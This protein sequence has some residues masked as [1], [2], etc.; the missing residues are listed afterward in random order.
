MKPKT[1][2]G[3]ADDDRTAGL[4]E[5]LRREQSSLRDTNT[6]THLLF[7][8][9][10]RDFDGVR[11]VLTKRPYRPGRQCLERP[12]DAR[13]VS[14]AHWEDKYKIFLNGWEVYDVPAGSEVVFKGIRSFAADHIVPTHSHDP[15]WIGAPA[16]AFDYACRYNAGLLALRVAKRMRLLSVSRHNI[17]KLLKL[18]R[19]KYRYTGK[20][21][22]VPGWEGSDDLGS[23]V[24]VIREKF[25]IAC[26]VACQERAWLR[27]TFGRDAD[28]SDQKLRSTSPVRASAPAA[29]HNQKAMIV[30]VSCRV[31][32]DPKF[33]PWGRMP[34][35]VTAYAFLNALASSLVS[36]DIDGWLCTEHTTPWWK[37]GV[38]SSEL[39]VS[40]RSF[41]KCLAR[42][43]THPL[44]HS[45]W[46]PLLF[47][48]ETR[49]PE[50]G[51]VD[52]A[53]AWRWFNRNYRVCKYVLR[54][55]KSKRMIR[56]ED[57]A[58][59]SVL[60]ASIGRG[61]LLLKHEQ[62]PSQL[63]RDI[64]SAASR[65]KCEAVV[66]GSVPR[67]WCESGTPP[68]GFS[69]LPTEDENPRRWVLKLPDYCKVVS[70][71]ASVLIVAVQTTTIQFI[72]LPRGSTF[73]QGPVSMREDEALVLRAAIADERE[74][75]LSQAAALDRDV[76]SAYFGCRTGDVETRGFL[77]RSDERGMVRRK[78]DGFWT[79]VHGDVR[80]A[81]SSFDD[82][83][84]RVHPVVVEG[85]PEDA[86][87]IVISTGDR[88]RQL[89]G[90]AAKKSKKR[91]KKA[92]C[93]R[94]SRNRIPA[95][96]SVRGRRVPTRAGP[97]QH[98]DGGRVVVMDDP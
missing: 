1:P 70:A 11:R 50:Y 21:D 27:A 30:K 9:K 32:E 58:A 74:L 77:R 29:T 45:N 56:T 44:D 15:L 89:T 63:L 65:C 54:Q 22:D 93:S 20:F 28:M 18:A 38:V 71:S 43:Q 80:H 73:S 90:G 12:E 37:T 19:R 69:A 2:W 33:R 60:H 91:A 16:I 98:H 46:Y 79:C 23:L 40:A 85:L 76:W 72:D 17:L 5:S 39:I 52:I 8:L 97:G 81:C 6:E 49:P 82:A 34:M 64:E 35:D 41:T 53:F 94:V 55:K 96:R 10:Y 7:G 68:P 36:R 87:S 75:H 88:R 42:D 92:A 3:A 59:V 13:M 48:G 4:L 31:R 26:S 25:G 57:R 83:R 51:D 66:V 24:R 86:V 14:F 95:G 67:D 47:P 84:V 61:P 78:S 62:D